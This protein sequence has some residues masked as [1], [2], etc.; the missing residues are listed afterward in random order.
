MLRNTFFMLALFALLAAA[1]GTDARAD[2]REAR[3]KEFIYDWSALGSG[4]KGKLAEKDG[5]VSF[6]LMPPV[7]PYTNRYLLRFVLNKFRLESPVP[8][9]QGKTN[10]EFARDCAIRVALNPPKT[11]IIREIE[12]NSAFAL[13][14]S[15]QTDMKT[16]AQLTLGMETLSQ[17]GMEF[18]KE[19]TFL[20]LK[21]DL[22][23]VRDDTK[24][25]LP[26]TKCGQSKLLG[27]DLLL[28]VNRPSERTKID[29][30]LNGNTVDII[31]DLEDC[32]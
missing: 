22:R 26:Q 18:S 16:L 3:K 28:Y 31:V 27:L 12:A 15:A 2:D 14:K 19:E 25:G 10:L 9:D 23:L 17:V 1:C 11:K 4:C 13:T 6:K 5:N 7:P 24:E 21:R 29:M 8:R 20:G 32:A 30:A